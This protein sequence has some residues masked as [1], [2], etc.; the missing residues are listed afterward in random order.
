K[1]SIVL[2]DEIE[3]ASD[4]LWNLMLGILD[5]A[6][7]TLGDNRTVD[8]SRA[9]IFMTSNIGAREMSAMMKPR[10]GFTGALSN[11]DDTEMARTGIE[12][13]CRKFTPEFINRIDKMVVFRP[14]GALD[15]HRI[16]EIEL[17]SVRQRIFNIDTQCRFV[18]TMTPSAKDF[19]LNEGTNIEYGARYLKR[20]IERLVVQPLSKLIASRQILR[21][22]LIEIDYESHSPVLTFSRQDEGIAVTDMAGLVSSPLVTHAA[23]AAAS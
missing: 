23:F 10:L 13:A 11:P 12:A 22:D 9:M 7:L 2:F 5:K 19:L 8:F 18:F 20:A 14:L 4:T 6:T 17:D 15:M 21:G 16:L 3:K 1:I